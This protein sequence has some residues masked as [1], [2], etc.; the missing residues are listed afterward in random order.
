M[1][2]SSTIAIVTGNRAEYYLLE[3]VIL[4]LEKLPK[5]NNGSSS[6]RYTFGE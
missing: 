6:L 2:K 1:Q 3:P 5:S 4:K